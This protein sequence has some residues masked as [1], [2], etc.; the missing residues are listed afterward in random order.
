MAVKGQLAKFVEF[1]REA[2]GDTPFPSEIL[3]GLIGR[4][5]KDNANLTD[6]EVLGILYWQA[7]EQ[8]GPR[9]KTEA[10]RETRRKK[11]R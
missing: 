1:G 2:I 10:N 5:P 8:Y 3:K 7:V 4:V 9:A 6:A 11:R